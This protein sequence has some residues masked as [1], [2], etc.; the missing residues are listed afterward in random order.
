MYVSNDLASNNIATYEIPCYGG[1]AP[2]F[3]IT[4]WSPTGNWLTASK[5]SGDLQITADGPIGSFRSGSVTIEHDI[6]AGYRIRFPV[7]LGPYTPIAP[8]DYFVMKFTWMG[9]N[10]DAD[11]AVEFTD[12]GPNADFD[13]NYR[14]GQ[15]WAGNPV[16][17]GNSTLGMGIGYGLQLNGYRLNPTFRSDVGLI[18]IPIFNQQ[19]LENNLMFFG[20]DAQFGEGETVFF[21]A[22]MLSNYHKDIPREI[23]LDVYAVWYNNGAGGY[24]GNQYGIRLAFYTYKGGVMKQPDS[25]PGGGSGPN[26]S[27]YYTNFYNIN[28]WTALHSTSQLR[29]WLTSPSEPPNRVFRLTN[30]YSQADA[31]RSYRSNYNRVCTILYD[32]VS[33]T[34]AIQWYVSPYNDIVPW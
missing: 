32:R 27:L 14:A 23:K 10:K 26:Q 33:Y 19:E 31:R 30:V 25:Q 12:N 2:T 9:N 5:V 24:V 34:A 20:G 16:N 8:F 13:T 4:G 22:P 21:N 6:D 3:K 15:M 17:D 28:S 29:P 11:V 18:P 7:E 1:N